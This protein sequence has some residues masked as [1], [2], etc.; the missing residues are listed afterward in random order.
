MSNQVLNKW[1]FWNRIKHNSPQKVKTL[2][3]FKWKIILQE[4]NKPFLWNFN[5]LLF[6]DFLNHVKWSKKKKVTDFSIG[7]DL[8]WVLQNNAHLK[9]WI[10][11]VELLSS[12]YCN[13]WGLAITYFPELS[14]LKI[15]WDKEFISSFEWVIKNSHS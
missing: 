7:L 15:L 11:R 1:L 3:C 4:K 13:K 6:S 10:H 2:H 12:L 5:D 9:S 8:D 14:K